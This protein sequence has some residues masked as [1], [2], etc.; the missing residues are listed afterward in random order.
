MIAMKPPHKFF[1]KTLDNDLESLFSYLDFMQSELL[2]Q[3]IATIPE[4]I[5]NQY[6]KTNGPTTQLGKFY[7]V[8][9]FDNSNI[10]NLKNNLKNITEEACEYYGINFNESEFMIHGWYN[11]DYKTQGGTGVSP[12]NNDIFFHDHAEGLGAPIFHGYYCVNAEPSITYYKINGTDLFENHNK[13]NRAIVSE[14]GH[15]H[16]RDDW[17]EDKPRITI[18]YDIAPKNS[19]VVTDLW[20]QL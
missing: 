18:A 11:L 12:L 4:D 14:T 5:I 20:I 3:K 19:H 2:S 17:Y 7:N 9:N 8:F 15:P 6:D 13:N 16:G 10:K 1:E